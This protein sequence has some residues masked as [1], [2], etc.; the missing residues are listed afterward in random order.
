MTMTTFATSKR[1][2]KEI[3]GRSV[4]SNNIAHSHVGVNLKKKKKLNSEVAKCRASNMILLKIFLLQ[5]YF[6]LCLFKCYTSVNHG[7]CDTPTRGGGVNTWT[8]GTLVVA[9][10]Q[11]ETMKE[12]HRYEPTTPCSTRHLLNH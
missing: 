4:V 3:P 12:T 8:G 10:F 7:P 5:M 11:R 6:S 1:T 9:I 2:R